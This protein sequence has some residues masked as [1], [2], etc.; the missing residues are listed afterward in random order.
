MIR[1]HSINEVTKQI[2]NL[3]RTMDLVKINITGHQSTGKSTLAATL[4]HLCHKLSKVP[5]TL[6]IF[7]R[8]DLMRF[9]DTLRTLEPMNHILVFDDVSFLTAQAGKR[10]IDLLQ[11]QYSEIRHLEGG[12]DVKMIIIFNSHYSKALPKF[13]RDADFYFFTN[14]GNENFEN[15]INLIGRHN[16]IKAQNFRKIYQQARSTKDNKFSFLLG[17]HGKRFTY[18]LF[19]PFSPVLFYNNNSARI[20]VFPKRDWIDVD[21]SVCA[22]AKGRIEEQMNLQ[23]FH[24]T[25]SKRYG[26][27][28][29]REALRIMMFRSF[30]LNLYRAEVK[31]CIK[32]LDDHFKANIVN[33]EQLI[34]FY[35]LNTIEHKAKSKPST[36]S[37]STR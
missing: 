32:K 35:E 28:V 3:T 25:F 1:T 30:G 37:I 17:K 2:L 10:H 12:H 16:E 36:Q 19:Q 24:E 5:F 23:E 33:P 22:N 34:E 8:D 14:I 15:V 11:Q 31:R 13:L 26:K 29:L 18:T 9:S 6:R 20:I 27:H 21:C 7:D 4:A